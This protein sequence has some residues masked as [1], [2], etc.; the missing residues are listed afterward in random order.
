VDFILARRRFEIEQRLDVAA[1]FSSPLPA[2]FLVP[3]LQ[4]KDDRLK[5][6]PTSRPILS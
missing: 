3:L 6:N 5:Q 2:S 1:H 4:P